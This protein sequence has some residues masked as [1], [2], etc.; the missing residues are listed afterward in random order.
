MPA[1][2][3]EIG[4]PPHV[5]VTPTEFSFCGSSNSYKHDIPTGLNSLPKASRFAISA[6]P[7]SPADHLAACLSVASWFAIRQPSISSSGSLT[8]RLSAA[9]RIF[10]AATFRIPRHNAVGVKYL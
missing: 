8:V 6:P 5:H 2:T 9:G 10:E 1:R 3:Q 4:E 7:C